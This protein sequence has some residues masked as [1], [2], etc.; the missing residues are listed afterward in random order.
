MQHSQQ[1]INNSQAA[2]VNTNSATSPG[3]PK[4]KN[5]PSPNVGI[6]EHTKLTIF[7]A[8]AKFLGIPLLIV[9]IWPMSL[10][11]TGNPLKT[12]GA[13]ALQSA[14][15]RSLSHRKP[16]IRL[17]QPATQEE[18]E[19]ILSGIAGAAIELGPTPSFSISEPYLSLQ[20]NHPQ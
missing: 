9:P 2:V 14:A 5:N 19:Y 3:K 17:R 7:V 13:T 11:R 18:G 10:L 20:A 6:H 8:T 16:T 4:R 12:C 1:Y 15:D